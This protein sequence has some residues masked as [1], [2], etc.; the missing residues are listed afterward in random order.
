MPLPRERRDRILESV[1][2]QIRAA[3][4]SRA[5]TTGQTR[6]LLNGEDLVQ[7]AIAAALVALDGADPARSD[8]ELMG[9]AA[10]RAR[11][12]VID[13]IRSEM[14]RGGA[15][16]IGVSLDDLDEPRCNADFSGADVDLV[17]ARVHPRTRYVVVRYL[18][19]YSLREIGEELGV[20]ESR[21]SQILAFA[22][23]PARDLAA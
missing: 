8:S 20:T 17:L 3:A 11:G 2:G 22:R 16:P 5:H 23:D 18:A 1:M 7:D 21:A 19:G 6:V 9:Y 15:R 13:R 14:G 12:A 10:I 4:W